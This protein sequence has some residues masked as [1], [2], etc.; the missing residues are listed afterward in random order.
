MENEQ[1]KTIEDEKR[2][3]VKNRS[4]KKYLLFLLGGGLLIMLIISLTPE[5]IAPSFI[6]S[7]NRSFINLISN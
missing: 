6:N 3:L 7:I 2:N 5:V 1:A 4:W